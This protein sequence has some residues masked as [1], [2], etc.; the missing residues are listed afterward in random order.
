MRRFIKAGSKIALS[1]LLAGAAYLLYFKWPNY[2]GNSHVPFSGF[3]EFLL[4]SPIAPYLLL[5]EL[6]A[7]SGGSLVGLL[8]FTVSLAGALFLFFRPRGVVSISVK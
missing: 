4:W 8:V 2:N 1:Y 5:E 6:L 3:P 7:G